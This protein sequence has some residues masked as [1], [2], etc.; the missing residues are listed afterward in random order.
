MLTVPKRRRPLVEEEFTHVVVGRRSFRRVRVGDAG[1]HSP[2]Q[3]ACSITSFPAESL[4]AMEML[5]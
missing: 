4:T 3:T 1:R 2:R 5:A